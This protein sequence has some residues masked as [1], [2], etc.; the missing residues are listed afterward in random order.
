MKAIEINKF[1]LD[2]LV[3][4]QS[5]QIIFNNHKVNYGFFEFQENSDLLAKENKWCFIQNHNI[6]NYYANNDKK[7]IDVLD[8]NKIKS[9][10]KLE[11]QLPDYFK[12]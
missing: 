10:K 6:S 2:N 5:V 12:Q 4:Y 11:N 7:L 1:I 3:T 8:G 9:I